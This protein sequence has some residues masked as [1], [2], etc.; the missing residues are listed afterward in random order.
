ML[1]VLAL[2]AGIVAMH[3]GVFAVSASGSHHA[4]TSAVHS[5]D[6]APSSQHALGSDH[7]VDGGTSTHFPKTATGTGCGGADCD[8][9]HAGPHGCV[10]ILTA[11]GLALMLVLLYYVAA[12]H[13]SGPLTLPRQWRAERV[14]PPPWTVLSLAELSILRI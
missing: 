12:G 6:H 3:A 14:R 13:P 10:F 9:G 4:A 1:A 8:S 2:L 7:T 11:L 5:A